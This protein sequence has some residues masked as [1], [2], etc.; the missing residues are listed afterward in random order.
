MRLRENETYF[1]VHLPGEH[2]RAVYGAPTASHRVGVIAGP[3]D[4]YV[5]R[6]RP[7]D[8]RLRMLE[9]L[10][11]TCC[12]CWRPFLTVRARVWTCPWIRIVVIV[13]GKSLRHL[14]RYAALIWASG[15]KR[16]WVIGPVA[17]RCRR[18]GPDC[19]SGI[20]FAAAWFPSPCWRGSSWSAR[21][22]AAAR[23]NELEAAWRRRIIGGEEDRCRGWL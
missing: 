6:Q 20:F 21:S 8:T 11:V 13:V 17:F 12:A 22:R 2:Y 14:V 15:V 16:A 19:S 23:T 5:V 7:A 9:P 18:A 1:I 3:S 4:W 10:R